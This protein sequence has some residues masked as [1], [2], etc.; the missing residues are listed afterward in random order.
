MNMVAPTVLVKNSLA[1]MPMALI[2]KI[3]G[4]ERSYDYREERL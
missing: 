2:E 1:E 3:Q 4:G